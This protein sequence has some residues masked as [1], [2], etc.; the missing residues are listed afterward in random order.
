MAADQRKKRVNAASLVGCTSREQYRVNRKKLRVQ[1]HDL[2]M[3]PNISLEW[4]NKKKCVVSK[5]EQIGI[6]RRHLISFIEPGPHFHNILADVFSVP[7]EIFELEN[8]SEVLSYELHPD[9]ILCEE[10]S[11]KTGKKT[12]YSDLQKYHYDS[13]KH[14]ERSML[15]SE[16]RFCGNEDNLVA[17]PESCSWTNSEIAYSSDNQNLGMVLGES[18]RRKDS[19]K[20]LSGNSSC[21]V[22]LVAAVPQKA[23][24]LHKRNIQHCD[25]AKYMSYIKVSREQHE[26]VKSSMK[27]ASNSIQPRYLSNVLG[28]ADLNVQPFERFEEEEKKRL[29]LATKDIPDGFA[30]WRKRQLQRQELT[31]SLG[32]EIGQKLERQ[33][34]L[35]EEKE[36]SQNKRMEL[37]DDGEEEILPSI[38]IEGVEAEQS[39]DLLQE[40]DN[41]ESIHEME[42]E[43]EDEKELKSDYIFEE[44]THDDSKMTGDD[45]N[46]PDQVF[47]QDHSQQQTASLNNSP[48][49]TMI[50]PPSPGFLQNRHQQ[51][52]GSLNSDPQANSIEM[53]SHGDNASVKTDEDPSIVSEYPGDPLPSSSDVWPVGDVHG[54]YYQSTATNAGYASAQELSIGT[55][56]FIP[57]QAVRL[58]GLETNR[59]DKDAGKEMLHRQTDDMSFFSSYPN[60]D[61]NE[62]LHSF[63]KG[64]Q[65]NLPY[66]HQPKHS[67]L[68]FQPGNDLMVDAGQFPGHF[69]EQIHP[70]SL[71]LDL[72]QK[73]LNDLYTHHQNIQ[74]S[75]YS[76]GR[77]A[78]PRQEDLPVNIHDWATV[79]SARMP[80]PP[81]P[82][83][84]SQNWYNTGDSGTRDG[85]PSL[86]VGVGANHNLSSV[87]NSDQTLFSVL[88]ECSELAPRASYDTIG[89]TERLIQVGNYSS[90]IGG[91]IP[92]GSSNFLQHPAN[93]LNY[94]SG[95]EVVG[96]GI[97][98]NNLNLGWMGMPQQNSG[99]QDSISKPPFLRSWNQ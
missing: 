61:R 11:L 55:T 5:R 68:E 66:H 69:R 90:G 45:D 53:E 57:E 47:I 15:P 44:R 94:L 20:K 2:S 31:W 43:T 50:T 83:L 25:G 62:L 52:I 12:Y 6:T 35:D 65:S 41:E 82:H 37:S 42:T 93:P 32:E 46:M 16:T 21:G 19:V 23:E 1:K 98:M 77:F 49:S 70:S 7:Q 30:N 28:I 81:Q 4:D 29:K 39:H 54:S 27:H 22:K 74:E 71:P 92:P 75:M 76:G 34:T 95:H 78:M 9:N 67:G 80:V 33:T 48:R 24:K 87:R 40:Q 56:Q 88:S 58:I 97:K 89:S 36:G 51:K 72:R 60:Q 18:R 26:R 17:T 38:T 64:Q 91:G 10:Q 13:R 59:Q 84:N 3:R 79:N 86:E 96:G 99:I 63:F 73:R 85:W 14:D 8:L